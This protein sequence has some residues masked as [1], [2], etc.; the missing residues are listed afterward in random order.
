MAQLQEMH[1]L[2]LYFTVATEG[3]D[4]RVLNYL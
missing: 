1:G 3:R 2:C 4:Q